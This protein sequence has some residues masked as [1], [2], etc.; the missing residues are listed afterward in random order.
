[1]EVWDLKAGKKEFDLRDVRKTVYSVVFSSDGSRLV[2]AGDDSVVRIWD[3]RTGEKL[4]ELKIAD[5]KPGEEFLCRANFSPDQASVVVAA[6]N[7][8]VKIFDAQKGTHQRAL[9][10]HVG[11][12]R[13]AVFSPNSKQIASAG[14]DRTVR[15][16]EAA[17]GN[18]LAVY[19]GHIAP[20]TDVAFSNDGQR[21][22]SS[23]GA[24][25]VKVWDVTRV[26]EYRGIRIRPA[27]SDRVLPGMRPVNFFD[28]RPCLAWSADS[29]RLVT[30][31]SMA[32]AAA[33]PGDLVVWDV[34]T[35]KPALTLQGHKNPMT[36]LAF[37]ANGRYLASASF[38]RTVVV[39]EAA[40]GK[41]V[42]T[43]SNTTPREMI[44]STDSQRLLLTTQQTL[45]TYEAATGHE[46]AIV[47]LPAW[48]NA[49]PV[50][51]P[52]GRYVAS[53]DTASRTLKVWDAAAG[54]EVVSIESGLRARSAVFSPDGLSLAAGDLDVARPD[55]TDYDIRLWDSRTGKLLA[56]LRGHAAAAAG[57]AWSPNGKRLASASRDGSLKIWDTASG[58]E[59][60]TLFAGSQPMAPAFSPDG[61]RLAAW[62]A[63]GLLRI[64]DATPREASAV[65]GKAT[66]NLN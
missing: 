6:S 53:G 18:L 28:P 65:Q 58:R 45:A 26:P 8:L 60:L 50:C 39:W 36:G 22:F 27:P 47:P 38:D 21:L 3:A 25:T 33:K 51:S 63:D 52:D 23:D 5:L 44:F 62:C 46:M 55:V 19:R 11:P 31:G 56:T 4:H 49:S 64:W 17:T 48:Q 42:Y 16:W 57:L 9:S 54:V 7:G 15:L 13:R 32:S 20:V 10:G 40:T 37:S 59:L 29:K 30:D 35:G 61:N 14:Q 34:A 41:M 1:V 24:G 66:N 12:V 43:L 2:T